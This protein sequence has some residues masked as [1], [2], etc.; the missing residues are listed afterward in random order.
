MIVRKMWEGS[1]A[2]VFVDGSNCG[3][4]I[5]QAEVIEPDESLSAAI[6]LHRLGYWS[7]LIHP[8]E[9]RPIGKGW[10]LKRWDKPKLKRTARSCPTAGAGVSLG[11]ERAPDGGWLM[12]VEVDGQGGEDS[13]VTFLGGEVP[14]TP[15]WGSARGGHALF[16][17]DGDRLQ[18]LLVEAGAEEGKDD[19]GKGAWHLDELPGLELRIGGYKDDGTVK[20]IQSV[21]P[22][23]VGTDG[24]KR[25]W[26]VS[27]RKPVAPLPEA[28]YAFLEAIAERKAIQAE[29]PLA[30][31]EDTAAAGMTIKATATTRESLIEAY[32]AKAIANEC[33][34]VEN[35]GAGGRNNRLNVAAFSLGQLIGAKALMRSEVEQA[36]TEAARRAGLDRD[37]GCGERGI[38][39]TIKSGLNTG[40]KKP[41]DLSGIGSNGRAHSHGGNGKP[42]PGDRKPADTGDGAAIEWGK[43]SLEQ[44]G[45]EWASDI[46]DEPIEWV[47][48]LRTATGKLHITAGA[49]GLGKSQHMI[50]KAA[51]VTTGGKFPDGGQCRR[52]G[53][54]IILA[55]EDGRADT[56]VPRLKAAGADLTK[57]SIQKTTL[58][59]PGKDGKPALIDFVNFQ[60]REYWEELFK[61]LEP[62]LLI[63]D[64]VPAF[65]GRDVNDHRNADVRRVLEPFIELLEKY[66]VA[67]ECGTHVGKSFKDRTATDQIL[68]SVAYSNLARRVD[69]TWMDLEVPGRFIVTN[70]KLTIGPPQPAIAYSIEGYSYDK[71]GKT[72]TTSRCKFEEKTFV[73]DEYDL[74]QGQ[75]EAR[76]G[77]RGPEPAKLEDL[78]RFLFEFMKG[79]GPLFLSDI[80]DAVGKAGHIGKQV[81]DEKTGRPRWKGLGRLYEAAD[82]IP[83]LAHPD[84]GWIVVT[85]KDRPSLRAVGLNSNRARWLLQRADSPS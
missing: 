26:R 1:A 15:S 49:G 53:V 46:E 12:D 22:P 66:R 77:R 35:A 23:T 10:G 18:K 75:R 43:L 41:R 6:S 72:I 40:E 8:D 59:I 3:I 79:K 2:F 55:C 11:P 76:R 58:I 50:A 21:V 34:A 60:N 9:K 57:V 83:R 42:N 56:I 61:R 45:V 16:G 44:L 81:E 5:D 47:N 25:R 68:G 20:Q 28:A 14:D 85:S 67:M 13:L 71:G 78:V 82:R 38:A 63:A 7:H 52:S 70:P 51:A 84:D 64:P 73:I 24:Q 74:A 33:D 27:P 30:E 19:K 54:V 39:A 32:A 80:I 31:A 17:P 65:M 48:D 69:M 29:E 36:L 37:P 4:P 62:V